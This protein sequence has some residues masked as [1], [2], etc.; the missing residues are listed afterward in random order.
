[1]Y[2]MDQITYTKVP[3]K[4]LSPSIIHRLEAL[5]SPTGMMRDRLKWCLNSRV[6]VT[7]LAMN[8]SNLIVGWTLISKIRTGK[9]WVNMFVDHPYRGN[10]I[11]TELARLSKTRRARLS[12][13]HWDT[14][15]YHRLGYEQINPF[16]INR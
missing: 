6:G 5:T 10:G 1:M 8:E 11:G 13:S 12:G 9:V 4:A 16:E 15:I 2:H 3:C 14:S 7:Y